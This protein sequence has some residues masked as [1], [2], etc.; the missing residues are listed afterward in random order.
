MPK[1]IILALLFTSTLCSSLSHPFWPISITGST[2]ESRVVLHP[3]NTD[4]APGPM[5]TM[6][7][8]S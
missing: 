5:L 4:E 8:Y 7:V 1:I 3:I 6:P 2:H